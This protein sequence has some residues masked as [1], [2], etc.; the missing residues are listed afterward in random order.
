[1]EEDTA[2][3]FPDREVSYSSVVG[4]FVG[5]PEWLT[6]E[7]ISFN[8]WLE[9]QIVEH[10]DLPEQLDPETAVWGIS[11]P[12]IYDKTHEVGK[13]FDTRFIGLFC[14]HCVHLDDRRRTEAEGGWIMREFL[15]LLGDP[16]FPV[17]EQLNPMQM[18]CVRSVIDYCTFVDDGR[19][20]LGSPCGSRWIAVPPLLRPSDG[21]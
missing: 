13:W 10:F 18:S 8:R 17:E 6:D 14:F 1:M 3:V 7:L 16:Q 2:R 19:M 21:R 9:L 11:W 20:M 12:A 15:S 5:R 4:R